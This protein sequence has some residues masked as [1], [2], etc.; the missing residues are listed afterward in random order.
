MYIFLVIVDFS[1]MA[2]GCGLLGLPEEML[3]K[4]A[5]H[6]GKGQFFKEV[7]VIMRI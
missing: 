5:K 6:L 4:I 2:A 3:I 1:K 7:S